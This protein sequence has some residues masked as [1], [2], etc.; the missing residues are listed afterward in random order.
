MTPFNYISPHVET[1]YDVVQKKPQKTKLK[2][3][4]PTDFDKDTGQF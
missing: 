1:H 4:M 2:C 3:F